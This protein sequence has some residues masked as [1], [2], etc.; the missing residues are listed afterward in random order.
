MLCSSFSSALEVEG[1]LWSLHQR[2]PS[3]S[4]VYI[5]HGFTSKRWKP[6]LKKWFIKIYIPLVILKS[7]RCKQALQLAS[8]APLP[9]N[10]EWGKMIYLFF[11]GKWH[12]G[13]ITNIYTW[14]VVIGT[15]PG[16]SM[17][18]CLSSR[19]SDR[20]QG[21]GKKTKYQTKDSDA[22]KQEMEE[23]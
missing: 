22:T 15:A 11:L 8:W 2:L 6:V 14:A 20:K 16:W 10:A 4:A 13:D 9:F 23:E 7:T 3:R 5:T 21:Q 1:P 12:W 17:K 19:R 18:N